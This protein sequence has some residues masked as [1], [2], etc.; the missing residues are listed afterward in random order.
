MKLLLLLITILFFTGCKEDA[1]IYSTET[2]WLI[3]ESELIQIDMLENTQVCILSKFNEKPIFEYNGKIISFFE[4]E[5]SGEKLN[6]EYKSL[7]IH[8]PKCDKNKIQNVK[9]NG[10]YTYSINVDKDFFSNLDIS[11]FQY[12]QS[13]KPKYSNSDNGDTYKRAI[14]LLKDEYGMSTDKANDRINIDRKVFIKERLGISIKSLIEASDIQLKIRFSKSNL[15]EII[16]YSRNKQMKLGNSI[17]LLYYLNDKNHRYRNYINFSSVLCRE[18]LKKKKIP[19]KKYYYPH[20]EKKVEYEIPTC[21]IVK[22]DFNLLYSV[23]NEFI[24]EARERLSEM[25]KERLSEMKK[26]NKKIF[27]NISYA[28]ASSSSL[29]AVEGTFSFQIKLAPP[30]APQITTIPFGDLLNPDL[31][32]DI[33]KKYS[34]F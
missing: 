14:N 16:I 17:F 27:D 26:R 31:A 20:L 25:E 7:Y 30:S 32:P 6:K 15:A 11:Y 23:V 5:S 21:M 22:E 9:F 12:L 28:F 19:Y 24:N 3:P 2:S 1:A 4:L 29:D 33:V 8:F 10:G 13:T 34:E 18:F